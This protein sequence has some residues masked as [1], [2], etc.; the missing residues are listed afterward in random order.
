MA[1]I[2][3]RENGAW[4][5]RYRDE[6]GR[7][8][9]RHFPRKTDA[10]RW[11]DEVTTS[12]VTGTYVDPK[13]GRIT[14]DAY[15][16]DWVKRQVVE[17]STASGTDLAVRSVP[18]LTVP[19]RNVRPSHVES[20][21]KTMTK[22]LAATTI[23]TRFNSVRP[24]FRAAVRDRVIPVDPTEGIKLPRARRAQAAMAIP[25]PAQVGKILT[26]AEPHMA[27][28]FA[29]CAFAGL[30]LGEA[31]GVQFDDID[32]LGRTLSVERQVQ[33]KTGRRTEVEVRDPKYGSERVVTLPD[34]LVTMLSLHVERF[35]T[36]PAGWVFIGAGDGPPHQNTVG[37][38]WRKACDGAGISGFRLHDL[39]H[40][41]ASGLI[42]AGCDV[43]TV[44]RALGH[45]KASTTLDTYSHLW[46]DA[47]DRTRTA[48]AGLMAASTAGFEA[49]ADSVRTQEPGNTV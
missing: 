4:R 29:L 47:E 33:R 21:V 14:F 42:A 2:Q 34:D 36:R 37:W 43:V 41:Y 8:H 32:F 27:A 31:A 28:L 7:E 38:Y 25:T 12:I 35:G 30:R 22:T 19:I 45:T 15:Y 16:K 26:A 5:A 24:I 17:R 39:R 3:R 20:W 46:P 48:A 18:F 11:L 40:F 23:R 13:A 9:A 1:S 6:A 10:Q 44:Q 49:L